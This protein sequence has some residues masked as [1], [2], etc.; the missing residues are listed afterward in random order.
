MSVGSF[1]TILETFWF[2]SQ[3]VGGQ[4]GEN[5]ISRNKSSGPPQN[6]WSVKLP[7]WTASTAHITHWPLHTL[8][9]KSFPHH[10]EHPQINAVPP[11][12]P[13]LPVSASALCCTGSRRKGHYINESVT[14]LPMASFGA[15]GTSQDLRNSQFFL[16][17]TYFL[18][19]CFTEVY[20]RRWPYCDS[21]FP[22]ALRKLLC[23]DWCFFC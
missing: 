16:L 7:K 21:C 14:L 1:S 17:D 15:A 6:V 20:S 22:T 12:L 8:C 18:S 5:I 11:S 2:S 23:L 4:S 13:T 10:A 9:R 19:H 3:R